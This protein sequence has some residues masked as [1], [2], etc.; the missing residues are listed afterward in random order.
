[1]TSLRV[2]KGDKLL[3]RGGTTSVGLAATAIAKE[4]GVSVMSTTRSSAR[5]AML[6]EYGA[7]EVIVDSGSVADEVK[8]I[9]PDGA[10]KV[11]ELIGVTTLDDS[12]KC[13][14]AGAVVCMTGI[15][16]NKWSYENFNPMEHIPNGVYLTSY[17][18][19]P[20]DFMNTPLNELVK[21]IADGKLKIPIGKVFGLEQAAEAHTLMEQNKAGG[22]VVFLM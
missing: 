19:G 14:R 6:R 20:D 2:Q 21:G 4:M 12:M 11:L 17:S 3:V 18:G 10:D 15:V 7:D 9:W 1:M 22:K 5:D 8:R 16:G 13:A